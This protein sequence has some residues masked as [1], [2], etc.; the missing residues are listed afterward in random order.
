M[1]HVPTHV[2]VFFF[3]FGTFGVPIENRVHMWHSFLVLILN[4]GTRRPWSWKKINLKKNNANSRRAGKRID[5][6]R[7]TFKLILCGIRAK[8]TALC[9]LRRYLYALLIT[10]TSTHVYLQVFKSRTKIL[11]RTYNL[12]VHTSLVCYTYIQIIQTVQVW[13]TKSIV[14]HKTLEYLIKKK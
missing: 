5:N 9:R 14:N 1:R 8:T 10:H 2:F 12:F 3:P 4:I 13:N 6:Y 11:T 7:R